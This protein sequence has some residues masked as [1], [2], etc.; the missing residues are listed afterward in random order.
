[1]FFRNK[2]ICVNR[3]LIAM[4][5]TMSISRLVFD[6]DQLIK[7]KCFQ[8]IHR[9]KIAPA[10][11]RNIFSIIRF[12]PTI[13]LSI[14]EKSEKLR[15]TFRIQVRLMC[16]LVVFALENPNYKLIVSAFIVINVSCQK[17]YVL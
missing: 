13:A 2:L 6:F 14:I 16:H 4:N 11:I 3:V 7:I 8:Y 15:T 5:I 1:V 17:Y 9:K 10:K 12:F